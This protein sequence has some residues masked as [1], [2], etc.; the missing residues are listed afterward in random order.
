MCFKWRKGEVQPSPLCCHWVRGQLTAQSN[1]DCKYVKLDKQDDPIHP[2]PTRRFASPLER[3]QPWTSGFLLLLALHTLL[4]R[5]SLDRG[6]ASVQS[7]ELTCV[8]IGHGRCASH[9]VLVY[10]GG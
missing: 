2:R 10:S 8:F 3:E 5:A 4:V 6:C 7:G 1:G 9:G